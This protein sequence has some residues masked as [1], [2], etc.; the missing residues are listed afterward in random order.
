MIDE[1]KSKGSTIIPVGGETIAMKGQKAKAK[2]KPAGSTSP[3]QWALNLFH[4]ALAAGNAAMEELIASKTVA[5]MVVEQHTNVLDDDSPVEEQW[6]VAG[7]P[8]GFAWINIKLVDAT[9]RKFISQL[10][11]AGKAGSTPDFDWTK[12]SYAG[13]YSW[14]CHEGGQSMAYKVA[15]AGAV[16]KVLG[17]AGVCAMAQSRMD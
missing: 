7:G 1:L 11:K 9:S 10:K 3:S 4:Q 14:Y 16:S 12:D 15:Y 2:S 13:G 17:D 8:C 6:V 5:P